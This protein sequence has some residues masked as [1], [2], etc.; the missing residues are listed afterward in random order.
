MSILDLKGSDGA[1]DSDRQ[2]KPIITSQPEASFASLSL[3]GAVQTERGSLS[4]STP[5]RLIHL[6]CFGGEGPSGA[7]PEGDNERAGGGRWCKNHQ[8]EWGSE[9]WNAAPPLLGQSWKKGA[10]NPTRRAA[11]KI[12]TVGSL[13]GTGNGSKRLT[14]QTHNSWRSRKRGM[15]NRGVAKRL[16]IEG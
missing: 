14:L 10:R 3:P 11:R 16:G 8:D 12:L 5:P 2:S 9:L 4:A 1:K 6:V 7:H 15:W 13:E